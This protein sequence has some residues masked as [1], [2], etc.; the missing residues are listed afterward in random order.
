MKRAIS[1]IGA[2]LAVFLEFFR[3][4]N[5]KAAYATELERVKAEKAA[6]STK[7]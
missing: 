4:G 2:V 7:R 5:L 1:S 3:W 6:K